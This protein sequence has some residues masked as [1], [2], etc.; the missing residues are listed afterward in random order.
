MMPM[1]ATV[2]FVCPSQQWVYDV[3]EETNDNI[4]IHKIA[5]AVFPLKHSSDAALREFI[6]FRGIDQICFDNVDL[7]A[8][9][10]AQ[11]VFSPRVVKIKNVP[12]NTTLVAIPGIDIREV[13]I[14]SLAFARSRVLWHF[15]GYCH[16]LT[17]IK[18]PKR[19]TEKD[20]SFVRWPEDT[21]R[22]ALPKLAKM[23]KI[24]LPD[25]LLAS[26]YSRDRPCLFF[27]LA[28]RAFDKRGEQGNATINS[29]F[30]PRELDDLV[31][32]EFWSSECALQQTSKGLKR[33]RTSPM[34]D[35]KTEDHELARQLVDF[36]VNLAAENP[37]VLVELDFTR[38]LDI[39]MYKRLIANGLL[40]NRRLMLKPNLLARWFADIEVTQIP[41]LCNCK[42]LLCTFPMGEAMFAFITKSMK[43]EH[44]WNIRSFAVCPNSDDATEPTE[45]QKLEFIRICPEFT[46]LPDGWGLL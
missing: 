7:S 33:V 11:H 9:E 38:A 43:Q 44:N 19:V 46:E 6:A 24:R 16:Y 36:V 20:G 4:N 2:T 22:Y 35:Q 17:T 26:F 15:L 18:L 41:L 40:R 8:I 21:L 13:R 1:P 27:A 39:Q 14:T 10:W 34:E 32:D 5:I 29:N 45:A 28:R 12:V 23:R 25:Q 30:I 3:Q 37:L 31:T 42:Q